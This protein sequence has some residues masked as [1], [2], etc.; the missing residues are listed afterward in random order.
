MNPSRPR[1]VLRLAQLGVLALAVAAGVAAAEP[2]AKAQREI[3]HLL[4]FVGTSSCTFVRN[5]EPHP[6]AD[7]REHLA[8]KYRFARGR[9]STADEFIRYLGTSSSSSGEP[10]KIICA[11]K[12]G[13]AGAWLSGELERYRKATPQR[14]SGTPAR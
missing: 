12:E 11:G 4:E 14:A 3:D 8:S 6:A 7:A 10:Y 5:G 1:T 13:P 2:D 9:I